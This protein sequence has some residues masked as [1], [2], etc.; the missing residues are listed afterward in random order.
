[1]VRLM[2][3][4]VVRR[5]FLPMVVLLLLASH[6]PA[7][8]GATQPAANAGYLIAFTA[9]L[10]IDF[11]D[12]ERGG[13]YLV[14]PDG[15]GLRQLTS[16]QTVNYDYQAH[17]L[18]LPDDHPAISPD[19][20]KVAFTSNRDERANWEI[21]VMDITGGNVRRL[22]NSAALDT[23][24]VFSPDGSK[25]A[26]ASDRSGQLDIWVMSASDGSGLQRLTTSALEDIE[27][28][29]S[30]DGTKIAFARVQTEQEKDVFIMDANGAN[31]RQLTTAAGE[32]HDP[33]FSPDG[34]QLVITSE[35]A[36][37]PPFGDVYKI[38]VSD[39]ASLGNLTTGLQFGGGDPAWSPDGTKVAFFRS[40]NSVLISTELFVMSASGTNFVHIEDRGLVNVHPN[41][42]VAADSDNDGRPDYLESRNIS[43]SQ[44]YLPGPDSSVDDSAGDNLGAATA[45]ADLTHDGYPDMFGGIPGENSGGLADS[46]R[47][48]M[49]LGSRAGPFFSS[50]VN[51]NF[52]MSID[53]ANA[54]GTRQAN[55]RFG[56]TMASCDFNRDGFTDLAIGAP[57]QARVFVSHGINTNWRVFNGNSSF[58][59]ALAPGDF[60]DDGYC[61]LAVG[62]PLAQVP[63]GGGGSSPGG[64]VLAFYG[65]SSGLVG[66]AQFVDQ[67][68]LPAVPDA[69]GVEAGDQFGYALAAGDLN[70]DSVDDLAIGVPGEDW[71]GSVSANDGGLLYALP[72]SA[73]SG[74]V[75]NQAVARDARSLPTPYNLLQNGALF[76]SAL[77]MADFN[78]D[79]FGTHDLVVGI[80]S[81]NIGTAVDA[82]L[83][84]IYAGSL[85]T[86]S[87]LLAAAA[88][89]IT[90]A[91]AG[92]GSTLSLSRFGHSLAVGDL[93]GDG[94]DDLAASAPS[95]SVGGTAEA[96]Q[97]YL[98]FG[99]RA[100][101][102]SLCAPG[103]SFSGG[104]LVPA[105]AQRVT[106]TAVGVAVETNDRFGGSVTR[107]APY[108][109]AAGDLDQDGQDD[110]A[111]GTPEED[112]G[113]N[114]DSGLLSIRYGVNVGTSVLTPT[115]GVSQPGET[116]TFSLEWTHP[117]RWHDL[118]TLHLRLRGTNGV[119][120]WAKFDEASNAFSLFDPATAT[121]KFSGAPGSNATL[122]T[123]LAALDLAG[124]T[125]VGS[126][127][128]GP[129]VTLTFAARFK[130]GTAGQV[131]A[132]ELLATDK[133]G[134]S[135]GFEQAGTWGVG[136]F[137]MHVP[138]IAR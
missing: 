51:F 91:D 11:L 95:Q 71:A 77:A 21:Y 57:G 23:E 113:S 36:G 49:M 52:P 82:G 124:S 10:E 54:G 101:T 17:G 108:A 104:G 110:L 41:W 93:S 44:G 136:P 109:L 22:T 7:T 65:S 119:V 126:G 46:G 64:Q 80:P 1:M 63:L 102:C 75:L 88:S 103:V 2:S 69:G 18:N 76:G 135:Q 138:L 92:G 120:F 125:V 40:P 123:P 68:R 67:N 84:A 39:G 12:L 25:I 5:C 38:R 8:L 85:G 96:G 4:W 6:S 81:Q 14:R 131:Y 32:D 58:G 20:K 106:Q 130:Q 105:S 55:G 86:S 60:N 28:A 83:L 118:E 117:E 50:I 61:D 29:W 132:V 128:E 48:A 16:F 45:F 37:T 35:R 27:P 33:T 15:S 19:G 89:A 72:G 98:I 30:P 111:I 107:P 122:D 13:I 73:S 70:G 53:A 56:Q 99:S 26:F 87:N 42:G 121:F 3:R 94:V 66:G 24:P 100:S 133:N 34:T 127:Q 9:A 116:V 90:T 137:A 43:F 134:N 59:T 47:V 115:S 74:L 114:A 97:L 31:Q 129:S 79:L 78:R 112:V 62:V